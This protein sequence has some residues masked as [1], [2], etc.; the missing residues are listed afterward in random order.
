MT[1]RTGCEP[2]GAALRGEGGRFVETAGGELDDSFDLCV[3]GF[4][5]RGCF[6]SRSSHFAQ[7]DSVLDGER[8]K[9]SEQSRHR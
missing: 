1:L 9:S 7:D 8:I 3:G 2:L 5:L 4:R 6:A